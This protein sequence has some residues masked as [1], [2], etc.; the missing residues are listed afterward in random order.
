MEIF[1]LVVEFCM[2]GHTVHQTSFTFIV[3]SLQEGHETISHSSSR[4]VL[5]PCMTSVQ[6]ASGLVLKESSLYRA[7]AGS[8]FEKK[9]LPKYASHAT[10]A[11]T[12]RLGFGPMLVKLLLKICPANNNQ[13]F[14]RY[15][16][17]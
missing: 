12:K 9:K 1:G 13:K 3:E 2:P 16:V 7:S 14:H 11:I 5:L 17:E 6:N 4:A 10:N 15:F 8:H